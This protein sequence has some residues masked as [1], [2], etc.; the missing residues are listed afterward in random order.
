MSTRTLDTR[1][2]MQVL[3]GVAGVKGEEFIFLLANRKGQ[4][5]L[6][7]FLLS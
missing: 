5:A 2:S 7:L 6:L 4:G 3:L 1:L